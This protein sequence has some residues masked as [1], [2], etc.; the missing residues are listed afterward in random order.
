MPYIRSVENPA[1]STFK[2]YLEPD[3]FFT[4]VTAIIPVSQVTS[5]LTQMTETAS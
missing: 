3:R 1:S 2:T 4:T 5:L